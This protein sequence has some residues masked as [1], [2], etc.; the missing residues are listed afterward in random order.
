MK[1]MMT[2]ADVSELLG[3]KPNTLRGWA[4]TGAIPC[5]RLTSGCIRFDV[6]EIEQMLD[7]R[8]SDRSTQKRRRR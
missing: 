6:Q 3:V 5:V 1:K 7:A 8:R 4:R 2:V